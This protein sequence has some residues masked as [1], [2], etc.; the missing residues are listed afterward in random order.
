MVAFDCDVAR[1]QEDNGYSLESQL[2]LPEFALEVASR[3]TGFVDYT[4][5][6]A[7]YARYGVAEHW[8]FDP[9]MGEYH[10]R[11]LVGDKL[12]GGRYER[13]P[14]EWRDDEHGRGYSPA[15]GLYVC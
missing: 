4:E 9:T 12:V 2:H 8:R 1:V 14:I 6:R 11:S 3:A 10:D 13:I 5:K 15:L 7:D